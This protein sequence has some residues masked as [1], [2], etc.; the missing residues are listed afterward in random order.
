MK[1]APPAPDTR[2]AVDLEDVVRLRHAVTRLARRLRQQSSA[3]ITPSQLA[4]LSG[5]DSSGPVTLG[6]LAAA[7]A[8]S[9]PSITRIVRAL[10]EQGLVKREAVEDDRRAAVVGVTTKA[11]RILQA[12]R[13]QRTA[14]L[15]ERVAEL[16]PRRVADL[17]RGVAAIEQLLEHRERA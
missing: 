13:S 6:E 17:R 7:E 16:P 15:A 14:W 4:V 8:V 2:S 9:P 3:G 11:R 5:L 10:E 1:A 12:I